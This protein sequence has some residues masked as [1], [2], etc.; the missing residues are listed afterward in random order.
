MVNMVVGG[1]E[2]KG[3][4]EKQF[5]SGNN[6]N[7]VHQNIRSLWGKG[8]ELEILIETEINNVEVLCVT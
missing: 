4:G 3:K 2:V 1:R 7:V 5:G 6:L 8:G